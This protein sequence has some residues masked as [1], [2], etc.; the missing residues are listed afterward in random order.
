MRISRVQFRSSGTV[1]FAFASMLNFGYEYEV[2]SVPKLPLQG[3][4]T[5]LLA[6]QQH[7][8]LTLAFDS[9]SFHAQMLRGVAE[10][11]EES[12]SHQVPREPNAP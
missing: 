6:A 9:L 11:A 5:Q 4:S 10:V 1:F 3:T 2:N 8:C 7:Q 12:S